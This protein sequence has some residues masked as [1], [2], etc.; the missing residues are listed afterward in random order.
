VIEA[1]EALARLEKLGFLTRMEDGS[2]KKTHAKLMI[3]VKKSEPEIRQYE[4]TMLE[5]AKQALQVT[6]Q[7]DYDKRLLNSITFPVSPEL[8]PEIKTAIVQFQRHILSLLKDK[9]YTEVYHFGCQ[10][11][12][13]SKAEGSKAKD[14]Q[15]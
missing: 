2:L 8:V 10:F 11:F 1:K 6:N 3:K 12:P 5:K 13:V 14:V 15:S 9:T 4:N 7:Q